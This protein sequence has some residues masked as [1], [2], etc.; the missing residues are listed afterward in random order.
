[1][2]LFQLQ[3]LTDEG[4]W[5]RHR[6]YK[7]LRAAEVA[8]RRFERGQVIDVSTCAVATAKMGAVTTHHAL[9]EAPEPASFPSF[10]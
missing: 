3:T 4:L 8:L 10:A 6:N 5:L 2:P 9:R 7:S 1:M